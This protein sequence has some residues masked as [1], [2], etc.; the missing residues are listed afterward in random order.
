MLA[1]LAPKIRGSRPPVEVF[2]SLPSALPATLEFDGSCP[3]NPGPMGVGYVVKDL[4]SRVLVRVGAQIGQGT[5]NEAEY[6][7]LL[8]GMRHA[9]KL[10]L[11]NLV[12]KSD[13]LLVVNQVLGHWNVK[14]KTLARL[15]REAGNLRRLFDNFDIY[16]VRREGN[17]DAD[18]LSRDMVFEEPT[19]APLPAKKTSRQPKALHD[20]QAAAIRHWWHHFN[21]GAGTLGRIFGVA[22]QVVEQIAYGTTYRNATFATYPAH[23]DILMGTHL[24]PSA[25]T[26]EDITHLRDTL[27]VNPW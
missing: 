11:W 15:W 9:L 21:P 13:S 23:L 18:A 2:P 27:P 24:L 22:P 26:R 17:Q 10:G 7:A 14:D 1:H 25:I 4:K 8:A 20:W 6:Q 19:L 5:N 16:H 12:V 3:L